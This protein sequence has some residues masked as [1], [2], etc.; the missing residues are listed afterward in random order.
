[1]IPK[2]FILVIK[3]KMT[4][5]TIICGRMLLSGKDEFWIMFIL[6]KKL[7]V[8]ILSY[9][10]QIFVSKIYL[11]IEVYFHVPIV[12]SSINRFPTVAQL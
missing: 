3:D 8:E 4:N 12:E 6:K 1:M 5:H 7:G 9:V 10:L 2:D 11:G